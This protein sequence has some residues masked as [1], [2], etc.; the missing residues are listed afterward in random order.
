MSERKVFRVHTRDAVYVGPQLPFDTLPPNEE[1][2]GVGRGGDWK[3]VEERNGDVTA[4]WIDPRAREE[5]TAP[6]GMRY[7]T[8]IPASNLKDVQYEFEP[9]AAPVPVKGAA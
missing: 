4:T 3:L 6:H 1:I 2:M 7:T 9:I 5:K 8:R